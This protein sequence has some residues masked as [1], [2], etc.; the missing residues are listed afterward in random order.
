MGLC[1]AMGHL[2]SGITA[3]EQIDTQFH[4]ILRKSFCQVLKRFEDKIECEV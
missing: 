1:I 3:T 4:S 2:L